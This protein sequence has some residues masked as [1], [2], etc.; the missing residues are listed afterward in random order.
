MNVIIKTT[1]ENKWW[2]FL[3]FALLIGVILRL[4]YPGDIEYKFD[5]KTFFDASQKVGVT[6]PWPIIG[7]TTGV[8][9]KAFGMSVWIFPILSRITHAS[10]PPELAR[11]VQL[12][13]ILGLFLLAFFSFYLLPQP[14][15]MSWR[16]ATV[17]AAVN[18]MAI[19]F[20]RKIW[21]PSTLPLFCILMWIAWYYRHKRIGAFFWGLIGICLGQI[22]MAGFFLAGGV[23]LWT[24]IHDRKVRWG[25][26]LA[27]SLIGGVPIIF[28]LQYMLANPSSGFNTINFWWILCPTYWFY[29]VGDALGVALKYTFNTQHF[30]DFLGYPMIG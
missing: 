15:R 28:W 3:F 11:S 21:N 12:L 18:P 1:N 27:G 16:W 5:E 2:I 19:L 13:N 24:A 6:E 4:A 7:P 10:T 20:Q 14:E 17:F 25:S 23:F 30:I 9:G 26:W 29:W 8:G 22:Q